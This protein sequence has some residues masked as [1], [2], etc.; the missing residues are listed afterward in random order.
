MRCHNVRYLFGG[1]LGNQRAPLGQSDRGYEGFRGSPGRGNY[2][3][4][5]GRMLMRLHPAFAYPSGPSMLPARNVVPLYM[6]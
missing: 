4:L 2:C 3:V 6:F 5:R 1:G